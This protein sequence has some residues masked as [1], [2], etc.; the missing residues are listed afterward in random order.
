MISGE[1]QKARKMFMPLAIVEHHISSLQSFST[2]EICEIL[3]KAWDSTEKLAKS[4]QFS[5]ETSSVLEINGYLSKAFNLE[6]GEFLKEEEWGLLIK[7]TEEVIE[8]DPLHILNWI[9]STLY[10]DHLTQLK[11]ITALFYTNAL[12]VQYGL[13]VYFLAFDKIGSFLETLSG[14]G[15]PIYDGQTFF[16]ES[17]SQVENII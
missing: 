4:K 5:F 11:L 17:H 8:E 3:A 10:W 12:R 1:V 14:S 16:L 2:C 15:P 9:F 13:P 7:E 6:H